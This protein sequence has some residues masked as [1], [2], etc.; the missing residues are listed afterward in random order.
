MD[1][2]TIF[3]N[4]L[5]QM[6]GVSAIIY[7]L[8]AL[9]L[10]IQFGYTGLLNF[11]QAGFAAI[12]AYS[13]AVLVVNLGTPLWVAVLAAML[14]SAIFGLI[15]GIPTLRLR[16]DY[17][18]IVTIAA[19]EIIRQVARSVTLRD[20]FGGSDGITGK[21]AAEW[22]ALNPFPQGL[23]TPLIKFGKNDF[24][25]VFNGWILVLVIVL[26]TWLLVR[27]PWGRVVK[28]IREDEEAV[29]SLGKNVYL[30]KMQALILGGVIGGLAGVFFAVA[31]QSV[32]PD[33][34]STTLTFFGYA[35]LILGGA[36]RV[37]GPVAGAMIFWFLL[38]F[39]GQFLSQVVAAGYISSTFLRGD[40]VGQVQ[41][42]LVGLGLMLLMIFRPQGIFGDKK[43]LALDER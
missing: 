41:F 19:A 6:I 24:W 1:W 5:T 38:V 3:S 17:L 28:S 11:G 36:A 43:E 34:Y 25:M 29:R 7:C 30:Y 32:Q 2:L 10:N 22:F 14:F 31:A 18:A 12:G 13:I 8:A 35:V 37:F 33:N 27:S 23:D 39:T 16:A 4:S 20:Y 9:G 42:M 15:L 40:Q 21:Y 26:L